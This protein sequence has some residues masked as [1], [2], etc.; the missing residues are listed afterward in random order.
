MVR[1]DGPLPSPR[2]ACPAGVV[3]KSPGLAAPQASGSECRS[4]AY[5]SYPSERQPGTRAYSSVA[6]AMPVGPKRFMCVTVYEL[7]ANELVPPLNAVA[8]HATLVMANGISV[9]ALACANAI[10]ATVV[11]A[12]FT[13]VR[14]VPA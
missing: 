3:P 8:V 4:Y 14:I 2:C 10:A 6:I 12:V 5:V 7:S 13:A 1:E 11:P 9:Y